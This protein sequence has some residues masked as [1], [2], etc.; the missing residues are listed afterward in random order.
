MSRA[1]GPGHGPVLA[2]VG[3]HDVVVLRL[4]A[5]H[6][7]V[8]VPLV[9]IHV[10]AE[11]RDQRAT[12]AV[13]INDQLESVV[14]QAGVGEVPV[15]VVGLVQEIEAV[16]TLDPADLDVDVEVLLGSGAACFF[17]SSCMSA[18]VMV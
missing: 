9:L 16:E 12:G 5:V 11:A 13:A 4:D 7:E 8:R 17:S 6:G 2:L 15:I 14:V 10:V 1:G 3:R 18:S